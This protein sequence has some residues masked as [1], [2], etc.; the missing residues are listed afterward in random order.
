MSHA[1]LT[2]VLIL[3]ICA[4]TFGIFADRFYPGM[5]KNAKTRELPKWFGRAWFILGGCVAAA[6]SLYHLLRK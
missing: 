1:D 6:Y 4:V 2:L 5:T 3:G